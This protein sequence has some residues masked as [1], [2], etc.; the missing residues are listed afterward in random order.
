MGQLIP[1]FDYDLLK[2]H[3]PF[4]MLVAVPRGVGKS[5]FV[6]RLLSFKD[7][8]ISN[9]RRELFD[10]TEDINQ[11]SFSLYAKKFP[12]LNFIKVYHQM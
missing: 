10:F 7:I 11:S 2:L 4:S 5:E 6:K 8:I 3:H 9:E 12:P 1:T